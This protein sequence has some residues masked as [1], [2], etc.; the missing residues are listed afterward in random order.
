M[1]WFNIKSLDE[2]K[3]LGKFREVGA[4]IKLDCNGMVNIKLRSWKTLYNSILDLR[5]LFYK[6]QGEDITK[7]NSNIDI[8]YGD[9]DDIYFTSKS[10]EYIF[11]LLELDGKDRLD[12]LEVERKFYA[13]KK[14]AKSWRD[15]I[16]KEIHPDICKLPGAKDAISKL[17]Q[18]YEGMIDNAK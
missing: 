2:L 14:L 17:N 18:L 3:K 9:N 5:N 6:L 16:A 10:A 15:K 1:E 12:K 13:N 8:I 4:K 11:Y 7:S